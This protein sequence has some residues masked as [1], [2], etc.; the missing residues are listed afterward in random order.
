MEKNKFTPFLTEISKE[1]VEQT[2]EEIRTNDKL[3]MSKL[4]ILNHEDSNGVA[5]DYVLG[6]I[7]GCDENGV[8]EYANQMV[9][10]N[11][12]H[13]NT[14]DDIIS[15]FDE[16][17]SKTEN[18][19]LTYCYY[20]DYCLYDVYE[21]NIEAGNVDGLFSI[22]THNERVSV[23]SNVSSRI[24]TKYGSMYRDSMLNNIWGRLTNDEKRAGIKMEIE[25]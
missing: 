7:K 25:Y 14:V 18:F 19:L 17:M 22:M 10:D 16:E 1:L 5:F 24:N 23:L 20:N 15:R 6:Q 3:L 2:H 12:T 8:V 13:F 4:S 11:E 21:S 9:G